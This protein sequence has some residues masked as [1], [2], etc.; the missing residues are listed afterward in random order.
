MFE[1]RLTLLNSL[2]WHSTAQVP[3]AWRSRAFISQLCCIFPAV[4]ITLL[5]LCTPATVL[6][7]GLP[8]ELFILSISAFAYTGPSTWNACL[9]FLPYHP[10]LT[11]SC[12]LR[13]TLQVASF[14]KAFPHLLGSNQLLSSHSFY[15]YLSH[16]IVRKTLWC[17]SMNKKCQVKIRNCLKSHT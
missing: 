16:L 3:L 17:C 12:P 1:H 15:R 11:P 6:L 4:T 7:S 8:K 14:C 10:E 2:D 5:F 13:F 9:P